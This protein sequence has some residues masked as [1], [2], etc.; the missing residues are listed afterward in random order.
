MSSFNDVKM[1]GEVVTEPA[2][3]TLL[4][5]NCDL[6]HFRLSM[7]R[8]SGT[9]DVVD[10]YTTKSEAVKVSKGMRV[11]I[12]GNMRSQDLQWETGKNRVVMYVYAEKVYTYNISPKDINN[13]C[14]AGFICAEPTMKTITRG[15]KLTQIVLAVADNYFTCLAWDKD[16]LWVSKMQV[17][18]EIQIIGRLQSRPYTKSLENGDVIQRTAYEISAKQI[19][20]WLYEDEI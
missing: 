13:V 19:N 14:I 16:A 15:G 18:A 2:L 4:P 1:V 12:I 8:H 3:N 11:S 17:G 20:E 5:C 10:V 6:Y 7:L 9:A